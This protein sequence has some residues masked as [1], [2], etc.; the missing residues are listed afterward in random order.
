MYKEIVVKQLKKDLN[1]PDVPKRPGKLM[2]W[3]KDYFSTF[4]LVLVAILDVLEGLAHLIIFW[5]V[6]DDYFLPFSPIRHW[7]FFLAVRLIK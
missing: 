7:L 3:A 2:Q 4:V 5:K 6:S 1:W